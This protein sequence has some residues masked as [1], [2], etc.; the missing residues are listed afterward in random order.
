M[1]I[2]IKGLD[3]NTMAGLEEIAERKGMTTEELAEEYLKQLV[4]EYDSDG[5]PG[6]G[7]CERICRI[8]K[9]KIQR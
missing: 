8:T 3:K 2:K 7:S 6:Y 5:K 1:E 9:E 4:K